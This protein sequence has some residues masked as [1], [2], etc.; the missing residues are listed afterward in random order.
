MAVFSV[1]FF[2]GWNIDTIWNI[3]DGDMSLVAGAEGLS[4]DV[5][6]IGKCLMD[7]SSFIGSHW[8]E[9]DG[10][11]G[12]LY[13]SGISS[14]DR[15]ELG[16]FGFLVSVT[17]EENAIMSAK[18]VEACRTGKLIDGTECISVS[19]DDVLVSAGDDVEFDDSVFVFGF[20]AA[21]DA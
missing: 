6:H 12:A 9:D 15:D 18:T 10:F 21:L 20:G 13:I 7:D 3:L 8:I 14:G 17:V 11:M 16:I 5:R 2:V 4:L 1:V 19:S